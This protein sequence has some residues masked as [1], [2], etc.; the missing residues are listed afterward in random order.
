MLCLPQHW[1]VV[2][3]CRY[4]RM[5]K[6]FH[7]DVL[8]NITLFKKAKDSKTIHL[9]SELFLQFLS[10]RTVGAILVHS[11]LD[12]RG[13]YQNCRNNS[14]IYKRTRVLLLSSDNS[15]DLH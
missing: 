15:D 12:N 10:T 4:V 5:T 7:A 2:F 3:G 8:Y 1:G 9:I 13:M 14:G 6:R 11:Q